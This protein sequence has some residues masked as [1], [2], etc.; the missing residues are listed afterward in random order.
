MRAAGADVKEIQTQLGHRS[1]MITLSIY[2]HLFEDAFDS[3]MDRLDTAH[4]DLVRPTSGPN[5]VELPE[6]RPSQASDQGV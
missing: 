4:R 1:P 2:T 5:V 6:Q 3:V